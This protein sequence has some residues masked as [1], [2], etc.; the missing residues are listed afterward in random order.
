MA[1]KSKKMVLEAIME[2]KDDIPEKILYEDYD[3]ILKSI[4]FSVLSINKDY[5]KI[6]TQIVAPYLSSGKIIIAFYIDEDFAKEH[7]Y[8]DRMFAPEKYLGFYLSRVARRLKKS[9]KRLAKYFYKPG[10]FSYRFIDLTR[11]GYVI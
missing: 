6:E 3:D 9:N 4:T 2:L 8:F 1:K 7:L 10:M 5:P 11:T